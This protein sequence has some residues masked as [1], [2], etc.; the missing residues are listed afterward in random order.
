MAVYKE[1]RSKWD[2][3]SIKTTT[4]FSFVVFAMFL[5]TVIWGLANFFMDTYYERAR[6]Q[7][8]I[9][10]ANVLATQ[11]RQNR[12][13]FPTYAVQTAG[14]NGIYIRMDTPSESLVY[15]GTSTVIDS[16]QFSEDVQHISNMLAESHTGSVSDTILGQSQ[17]GSRLLYA[18]GIM[19]AGEE[20]TLYII[21][22]LHPDPATIRI[23]RDMLLYISSIVLVASFVLAYMLSRRITLPIENLT[24][25]ATELS[26]GNYNVKFD[27]S[28]FTETRELAR[29]LNKASYEMEK[30][31]FYQREI[32]ANV[33]HDLKTP[34]TMIRSYAE[35]I[36]DISGDNPERRS[37]DLGVIINETERLNKLVGDIMSVSNLQSNN[38]ELHK[39]TFDIV[40]AARDVYESYNVLSSSQGFEI[41]FHPCKSCYVVGDRTRLM[42]VMNNFVDNAVKYA[43]DG[44][45][46]DIKLTRNGKN[47]RFRCIDHGIGIPSDEI[48]H[49]WDKYYRTSANHERAIEGTGLG[50]AIVKGILTLHNAKYGVDSKEGKGSDFWFELET[51]RKPNKKAMSTM[52]LDRRE[53]EEKRKEEA[54]NG[55]ES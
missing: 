40:E 25:S 9:R 26:Q 31:D 22:P 10:T 32:L 54:A 48:A 36:L 42:Q 20:N 4:L 7:E 17:G 34:L 28:A 41:H 33:S 1:E 21:A 45:Y 35:K 44:K 8:V 52:E 37:A 39:E 11:F 14:A 13:D 6:S 27:G 2:T 23:L 19:T 18:T 47:V 46:I 5:L 50:L 38:I 12:K 3:G 24:S 51:V 53:I 55:Q 30:T 16:G 43:G 49:V 29:A 15:D